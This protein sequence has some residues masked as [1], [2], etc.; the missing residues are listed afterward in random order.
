MKKNTLLNAEY[1]EEEIY[2]EMK[3]EKP[4][5]IFI[6]DLVWFVDLIYNAEHDMRGFLEN[7]LEKGF[8][9]NIF[10]FGD[11]PLEKRGEV[12][13][14]QI[15]EH[16]ISYKTGIHLGGKTGDNPIL[17][18]DYLSYMEKEKSEKP[19]IGSLPDVSMEGETEKVV[20]PLARR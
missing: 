10:F 6:S 15:Y 14:Y 17:N 5:F 9:H 3:R 2:E 12:G 11:L 20:I 16:F 19:G 18:F 4:Y 13:G 8:L 1:E 7:I